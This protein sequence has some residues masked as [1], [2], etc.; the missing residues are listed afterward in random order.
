MKKRYSKSKASD[1]MSALTVDMELHQHI[2]E[3]ASL[4]DMY[5]GQKKTT[6]THQ[7][8]SHTD[9]IINELRTVPW[10]GKT[11]ACNSTKG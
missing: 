2:I 5:N 11:H 4:L 8:L 1:V 9:P 6:T 10:H 7:I 3:P